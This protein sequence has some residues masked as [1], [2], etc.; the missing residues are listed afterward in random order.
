M[1]EPLK[2]E[3]GVNTTV[4]EP[5]VQVPTPAMVNEP[6]QLAGLDGSMMQPTSG[7]MLLVVGLKTLGVVG[8]VSPLAPP[9]VGG[10][11]F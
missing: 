7:K 8:L 1:A 3:F 4:P 11:G 5:V 9:R 6:T 2:F 10:A